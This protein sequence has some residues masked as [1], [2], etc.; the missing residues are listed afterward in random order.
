MNNRRND[1]R[2]INLVDMFWA[3]CLKWRAMLLWGILFALILGGIGYYN[4]ARKQDIEALEGKLTDKDRIQVDTYLTYQELYDMQKDYNKNSP[5]MQ[6][7]PDEFYVN[8]LTYYVDNHHVVEYPV[9]SENDNI[10]ALMQSYRTVLRTDT[11][12]DAI[13]ETM[14]MDE[15]EKRYGIELVDLYNAYGDM[16]IPTDTYNM[17][18]ITVYGET[19][20][21]CEKLSALVQ[22]TIE[23]NKTE[24]EN[25]FGAHDITLV[26]NI[27][28]QVS[29][30]DLSVYQKTN[31]D[32]LSLY[33][34]SLES[35]AASLSSAALSYADVVKEKKENEEKDES[36][37]DIKSIIIG[38]VVG[39]FAVIFISAMGYILN[40]KHRYEDDYERTYGVKFLGTVGS[41]VTEKKKLFSGV[42]RRIY[43][44]RHANIHKLTPGE[45]EDMAASGIKLLAKKA[46]ADKVYLTGATIDEVSE[47]IIDTFTK[48]LGKDGIELVA[49]KPIIYN[50]EALENASETGYIVMIDKIGEATYNQVYDMLD[51]CDNHKICVLGGIMVR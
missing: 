11:F 44:K 20:Q 31:I 9:I 39:L 47:D 32:N 21:D 6:L 48:R 27:A 22:S 16:G 17:M 19:L 28:K 10:Y 15:A 46:C 49:G 30:M 3:V 24:M 37:I 36:P 34:T 35:S 33:D 29:D 42:D 2:E 38:F 41:N 7:D 25:R 45:E 26:D 40:K 8:V 43:K 12:T 50:A 13:A 14:D 18:T 51:C 5:L 4:N 23:E 1:E